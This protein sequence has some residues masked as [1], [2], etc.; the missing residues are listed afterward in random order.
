MKLLKMLSYHH[1][2][3]GSVLR[4]TYRHSVPHLP[5]RWSQIGEDIHGESYGDLNGWSV[6]LS[7]DGTRVA[8]GAPY[9]SEVEGYQDQYRGQVRLFKFG[10]DG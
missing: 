6:S 1:R 3:R 9:H 2:W 8:I 10:E 5:Y 7:S 4:I